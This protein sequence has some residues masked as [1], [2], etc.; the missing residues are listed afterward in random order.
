MFMERDCMYCVSK[1][2]QYNKTR[3]NLHLVLSVRIIKHLSDI[4]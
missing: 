3:G 4:Q 1:N 2:L